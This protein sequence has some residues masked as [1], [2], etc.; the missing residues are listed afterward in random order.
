MSEQAT[1]VTEAA[2]DGVREQTSVRDLAKQFLRAI[3]ARNEAEQAVK[4]AQA[5]RDKTIGEVQAANNAFGEV[6][7]ERAG[8][9]DVHDGKATVLFGRLVFSVTKQTQYGR[10]VSYFVELV[11]AVEVAV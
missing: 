1:V 7:A 8:L 6:L 11:P 10:G 4:A 5:D 9:S 3:Q 2:A